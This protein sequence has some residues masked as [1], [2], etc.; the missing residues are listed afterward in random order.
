MSRSAPSDSLREIYEQRAA[1]EYAEPSPPPDF[2]LHRKFERVWAAV[3]AALPRESF[4]DA[5]CG[6]GRHLAAFATVAGRPA[7]LAG[8]D[9]SERILETARRA[10]ERA[11]L[12]AELARANLESLPFEDGEFDLVL[13][14]Q[15]IEHLLDPTRG[16]AEL[17]RVLGPGGVLVLSTDHSRN[18]VTKALNAPR[19]AVVGLLRLRGRR[20]RVHFPHAAFS[21]DELRELVEAAGLEIEELDTFRFHLEWPLDRPGILRGLN[22][23]DRALAPHRLGDLLLVVARKP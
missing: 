2:R 10:V 19:S 3:A 4:L 1:L 17:A 11:G 14:T 9:I 6:D 8:V 5:G 16:V 13:S 20:L 7:R 12:N 22:R 21:M 23:L 15:V 18:L